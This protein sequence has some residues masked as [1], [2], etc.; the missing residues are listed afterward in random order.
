VS[1][2]P[3]LLLFGQ[4]VKHFRQFVSRIKQACRINQFFQLENRVKHLLK[5]EKFWDM[6][7]LL[8][9]FGTTSITNDGSSSFI[10]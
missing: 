1:L 4:N 6:I 5:R 10:T 2:L 9:I 7:A 8:T 3:L